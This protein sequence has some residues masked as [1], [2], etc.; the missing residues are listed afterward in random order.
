MSNRILA[1]I[2]FM[3]L[4][5]GIGCQSLFKEP[6]GGSVQKISN[7]INLGSDW[8]EFSPQPPIEATKSLCYIGLKIS[9]VKG[10]GDAN[11]ETIA[12]T[13]GSQLKIEIELINEKGQSTFLFPVGLAE[14]V[15]FGKRAKNRD[16]IQDAYFIKGEKFSK[17]RIK[18]NQSL[19]V[20]EVIWSE[21]EL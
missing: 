9:N 15:E 8:V 16:N 13:D 5:F 1:G 19:I 14:F 10:W 17:I 20:D 2:V 21:L 3:L 6:K 11:N 12:L 7:K 4:L 18:A